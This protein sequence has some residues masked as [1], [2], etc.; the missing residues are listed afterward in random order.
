M[1]GEE[2]GETKTV[3]AMVPDVIKVAVIEDQR[4]IREGLQVLINGSDGY[5]CTGAF[6]TMEEALQ[7][8]A[9]ETPNVVLVDIG[10]PGMSGIEGIP[11]LKERYPH[12]LLL[13]LT[14]YDD[15]ERIFQTLCAGASGYLLKKTPPARLLESLKEVVSGGA[16]MSPE[17][18]RRV[19][20]LFREVHP[21]RSEERRVG[22]ECRL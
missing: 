4:E 13:A 21:P 9:Y 6:R 20:T 16:P 1:P 18:A 3:R 2:N 8:I 5:R 7:K 14:V 22:K 15:D 11:L 12:T 10:L 19:I 17:V